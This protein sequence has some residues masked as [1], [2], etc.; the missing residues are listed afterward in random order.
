TIFSR[1]WSS[2]VCSSDLASRSSPGSSARVR[3]RGCARGLP[4]SR[5]FREK[6]SDTTK[7]ISSR[8]LPDFVKKS[9]LIPK[10]EASSANSPSWF[11]SEE[12]TS[13]L[14]SRENLV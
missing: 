10:R 4:S 1:D 3:K 6:R 2:D 9:S 8:S 7:G 12:H 11:R 5:R 13:E 14:Q